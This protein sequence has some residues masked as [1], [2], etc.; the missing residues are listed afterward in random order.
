MADARIRP[1]VRPAA[2]ALRCASHLTRAQTVAAFA[3]QLGFGALPTEVATMQA[4]DVEAR[5]RLIVQ[6]ALKFM[7]HGRRQVLSCEDV[8]HALRLRNVE[9]R[10]LGLLFGGR[11]AD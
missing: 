3:E 1:E 7:R 4:L 9:A 5:V 6:E 2:C 8:N 10:S 11:G